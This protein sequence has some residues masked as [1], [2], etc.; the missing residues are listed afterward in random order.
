MLKI[1]T[2]YLIGF[3]NWLLWMM[4]YQTNKAEVTIQFTFNQILVNFTMQK[5]NK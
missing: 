1:S 4:E 2:Y 3:D 5:K